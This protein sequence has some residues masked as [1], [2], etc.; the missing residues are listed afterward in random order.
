M[1]AELSR[2]GS[3]SVLAYLMFLCIIIHYM[4]A[5]PAVNAQTQV[6]DKLLTISNN[7]LILVYNITRT[8]EVVNVS[9]MPMSYSVKQEYMIR[10]KVV[11]DT[12]VFVQGFRFPES[13]IYLTLSSSNW[14]GIGG[15]IYWILSNYTD[16]LAKNILPEYNT[17]INKRLATDFMNSVFVLPIL[18]GEASGTCTNI[19]IGGAYI[20]GFKAVISTSLGS[21]NAYYDCKYGILFKAYITKTT[22][23]SSGNTTHLIKDSVNLELHRANTE[24]LNEIVIKERVWS[25][26]D[27]LIY[28]VPATSVAVAT[29]AV[30]I[31][32]L[33]I[34][35]KPIVSDQSASR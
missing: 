8:L 22:H 4:S 21:G 35:R 32:V 20:S 26:Y 12:H 18:S 33:K 25:L 11:N 1:G 27:I 5:T 15:L 19:P 2:R 13:E 10:V 30:L 28:V 17:T 7:D 29:T 34:R 9:S 31:Y 16:F 23:Q 6:L 14:V 24:I 3:V